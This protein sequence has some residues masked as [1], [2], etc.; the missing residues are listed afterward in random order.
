MTA[1]KI[2][3]ERV[4]IVYLGM[5]ERCS[6]SF[7]CRGIKSISDTT[8][9]TNRHKARVRHRKNTIRHGERC[10]DYDTEVTSRVRRSNRNNG[11]RINGHCPVAAA[12]NPQ[13]KYIKIS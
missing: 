8:K 12:F 2:E 4:A 6:D 7:S 9:V 5:N 1:R 13:N 3:K 10:V 11:Y